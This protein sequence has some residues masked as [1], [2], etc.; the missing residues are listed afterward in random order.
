[1]NKL[2]EIPLI[3]A[4]Q[5]FN[6]SILQKN[7]QLRLFYCNAPNGGWVLDIMNADGTP[8][9][10][11]V[12]LVTGTNLLEQFSYIKFSFGLVVVT[13]GNSDKVPTFNNLGNESYLYVII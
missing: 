13:D 7:Y 1:M 3:P 9:L 2:Y 5:S 8:I 4:N 11:G 6:I 10:L 12:P